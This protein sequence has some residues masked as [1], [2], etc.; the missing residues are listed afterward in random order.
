MEVFVERNQ[1]LLHHRI[2]NSLNTISSILGLQ[3]N[4]LDS[5]IEKDPK[6]ILKNSKRRIETIA[7][8]HDSLCNNLEMGRVEFKQYVKDLT[9]MINDS[10]GR[11]ISVEIDSHNIFLSMDMMFFVGLIVGELFTNSIKYAFKNDMSSDQV[12]ISFSKDNNRFLFVYHEYCDKKIDIKKI[13]ES[14]ALGLR[15]VKLTV[16]QLDGTFE[17]A[18]DNGLIFTI[19]FH[20]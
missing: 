7:M 17:V 12:I 20:I 19:E 15:L 3:I 11:N 14:Q 13:L 18:Q 2:K 8:N 10:Y 4:S 6:E 9:D 16:K 5:S 1:E